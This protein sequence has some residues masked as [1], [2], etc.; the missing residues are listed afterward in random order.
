MLKSVRAF[1]GVL[2]SAVGVAGDRALSDEDEG[3][4]ALLSAPEL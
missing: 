3:S 4:A 2:F 1:S